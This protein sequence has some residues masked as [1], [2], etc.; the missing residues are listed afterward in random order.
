MTEKQKKL[1]WLLGEDLKTLQN[2]EYNGIKWDSQLAKEKFE[3]YW[4]DSENVIQYCGKDNLRQ[5][6]AMWQA[7]LMAAGI[8]NTSKVYARR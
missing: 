1:V 8:K 6:S 7:M 3:K 5:Q 2:A 4:I